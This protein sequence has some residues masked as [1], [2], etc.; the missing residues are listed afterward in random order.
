M[1]RWGKAAANIADPNTKYLEY[2]KLLAE[3]SSRFN[4]METSEE[5]ADLL[6]KQVKAIVGKGY[7]AVTL[8][9]D[10]TQTL[11][12]KAVQGFE[13]NKLIS[14]ALR[15]TGTDPLKARYS[16][17]DMDPADLAIFRS[18]R[19]QLI[20]GGIYTILVRKFPRPG[21]V[22]LERLLGIRF[23]YSMGFVHHQ[24]HN[25]GIVILTDLLVMTSLMIRPH[26][27]ARS[28]PSCMFSI[29]MKVLRFSEPKL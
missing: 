4:Q 6:C 12:I 27:T 25:G 10:D 19:L 23:V 7:V 21:T 16:V 1:K 22:A 3:T 2:L 11:S 28:R 24:V 29:S 17:K 26:G 5:M 13:D 8:M 18:G 15:L 9:D 20:E 14:A